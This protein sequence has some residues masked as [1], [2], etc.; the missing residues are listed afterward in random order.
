MDSSDQ[1]RPISSNY[2][3]HRKPNGSGNFSLDCNMLLLYTR[4]FEQIIGRGA[5]D[6]F[7]M[8]CTV[9]IYRNQCN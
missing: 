5:Y 2:F 3:N 9:K 6:Y 8:K 7:Y 1:A 4:T